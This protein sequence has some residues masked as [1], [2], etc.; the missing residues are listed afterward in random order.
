MGL[1]TEV[2]P[3]ALML[4]VKLA[5]QVSSV[6]PLF[7][8]PLHWLTVTGAAKLTSDP[9]VDAEATEQT[10]V[11]PPPV[12]EPLH[13]VTVAGSVAAGN[14]SQT[15]ELAVASYLPPPVPVPTHWLD[16]A[17]DTGFA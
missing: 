2:K 17:A 8:V 6:P 9:T 4:V 14:G 15:S 13:W 3:G 7:P 10:A 5:E 16:V 1:S 12:A 11:E